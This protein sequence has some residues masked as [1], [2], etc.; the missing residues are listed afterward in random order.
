MGAKMNKSGHTLVGKNKVLVYVGV[1][2]E[3]TASGIY[4]N[5]NDYEKNKLLAST[6]GVVVD[7]TEDAFQDFKNKPKLKDLVCFPAFSAICVVE[8]D[9][10][11][12][13]FAMKDSSINTI[14]RKSKK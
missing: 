13:Y 14:H 8:G 6:T 7:M 12:T 5:I 9:D 1:V 2:Q 3:K 11:A 4:T 10:G